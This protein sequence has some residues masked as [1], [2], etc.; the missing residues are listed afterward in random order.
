V[1]R[2]LRTTDIVDSPFARCGCAPAKHY[3]RID[4]A[5]ALLEAAVRRREDVPRLNAP[6]LLAA[7]AAGAKYADGIAVPTNP[8]RVAA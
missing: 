2:Y 6:R 4:N 8:R 1:V 7:V 3:K 5:T